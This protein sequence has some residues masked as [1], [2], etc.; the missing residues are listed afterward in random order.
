VS[1][2]EAGTMMDITGIKWVR[3]VRREMPPPDVLGCK[4]ML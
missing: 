1:S 4:R 3:M 2:V